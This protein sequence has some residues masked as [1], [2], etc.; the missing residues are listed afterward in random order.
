VVAVVG[1]RWP[2]GQPLPSL[3]KV[4]VSL[5]VAIGTQRMV[6]RAALI[7]RLPAVGPWAR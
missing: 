3:L 2:L 6:R 1:G 5:A 4:A 7:R